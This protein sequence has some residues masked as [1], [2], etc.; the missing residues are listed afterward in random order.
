[1]IARFH[2]KVLLELLQI[3]PVVAVIGPRQVGKSTMV[4]SAS[5]SEGRHY[6]TMDD[7]SLRSVAESDPKA[8][9]ARS[10]K[11]TIDEIQLVPDLLREIKYR[12]DKDPKPGQFLITGSADL[13]HCADLSEIL[14]GRVGIL[15]LP[16]VCQSEASGST[17]WQ[18]WLDASSVDYLDKAY[19]GKTSAVFN[20]NRLLTGGFPLALTAA[21]ERARQLWFE[22]FRMTYLERDLRRISDIS[23]LAEF[24]RL[25]ELTA[26]VSGTLLNQAHLARDAGMSPATAGR[27]L[28]VLEASLLIHRLSPYFTNVGKRLVKSPKLYW[29][30]TGLCAYLLG[31]ETLEQLNQNPLIKGRLFES[32][33]MMEVKALLEIAHPSA[34]LLHLRTHDQL[35]V[36]GV[37]HRGLNDMLFEIKASQTVTA[38]DAKPM[39]RWM[40]HCKRNSIGVVI[41]PGTRYAILSNNVRAIPASMLFG[42]NKFKPV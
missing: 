22:S 25:M 15:R 21:N 42:T 20:F 10:E 41:Y 23:H 38:D 4:T 16:P 33:V 32:F 36:D 3:F 18:P 5:I 31:L 35:E 8:F 34:R 27:Y 19:S 24:N 26:G 11:L 9:L 13:D 28:S 14:A 40:S 6:L 17:G 2:E 30:D 7:I 29:T 1:M 39:E 37:I 12:V